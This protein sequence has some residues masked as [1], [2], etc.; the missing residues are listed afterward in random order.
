MSQIIVFSVE[1]PVVQIVE[2]IHVI[3]VVIVEVIQ[4][5]IVEVVRVVIIVSVGYHSLGVV[6]GLNE[7]SQAQL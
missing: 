7:V 1:V 2:V 3:H 4:V 6:A 5:V